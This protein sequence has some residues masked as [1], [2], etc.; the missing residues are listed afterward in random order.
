MKRK[1]TK[2]HKKGLGAVF[3]FAVT[4]CTG[5][6]ASGQ[7][8][9]ASTIYTDTESN[10]SHEEAQII[11]KN[12][13]TASQ[14]VS[15]STSVYRYVTGTLSYDDEDWYKVYLY[16]DDENYLDLNVGSGTIYTI[17]RAALS[18]QS[19]LFLNKTDFCSFFFELAI[20]R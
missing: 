10:N 2:W 3:A 4:L 14:A 13:Q 9:Y 8:A 17:E 6:L 12:A 16:S 5:L 20:T 7:T 11:S 18:R 1:F 19:A 15:G